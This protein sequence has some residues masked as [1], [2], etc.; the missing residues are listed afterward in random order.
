MKRFCITVA[1]LAFISTINAQSKFFRD[2]SL[3]LHFSNHYPSNANLKQEYNNPLILLRNVAVHQQP[4]DQDNCV[5]KLPTPVLTFVGKSI[6]SNI[7]QS[8][9]DNMYVIKPDSSLEFNMPVTIR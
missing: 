7:Y 6:G 3:S 5:V 2:S 4:Q 8:S 1:C 9:P